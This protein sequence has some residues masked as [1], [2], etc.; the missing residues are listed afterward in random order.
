MITKEDIEDLLWY[1]GLHM[2]EENKVMTKEEKIEFLKKAIE[3][4]EDGEA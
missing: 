3:Q 4:L 2:G 1:V